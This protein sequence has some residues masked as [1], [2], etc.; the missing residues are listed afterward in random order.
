MSHLIGQQYIVHLLEFDNCYCNIDTAH[1]L[2]LGDTYKLDVVG[3]TF[4][5]FIS[6]AAT[7]GYVSWTRYIACT[8]GK[9]KQVSRNAAVPYRQFARHG[10]QRATRM[11]GTS[12]GVSHSDNVLKH[13]TEKEEL[14]HG[15]AR[16]TQFAIVTKSLRVQTDGQSRRDD[17][18]PDHNQ[19]CTTA[20]GRHLLVAADVEPGVHIRSG[21]YSE[22][23]QCS[24]TYETRSE[25]TYLSTIGYFVTDFGNQNVTK[26]P[27]RIY[28]EL[29][30][31]TY[32]SDIES[33]ILPFRPI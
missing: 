7:T 14:D 17:H 26:V 9:R 20:P 3:G 29:T 15:T 2:R 33:H 8:M 12:T 21:P 24:R 31:S 4:F 18:K 5:L 13:R 16:T 28:T 27:V 1:C 6:V 32:I 22:Y 11:Q 25:I 19:Q 23:F 30:H 10:Q